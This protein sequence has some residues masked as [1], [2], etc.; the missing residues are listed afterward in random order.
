[1]ILISIFLSL[2]A[3]AKSFSILEKN[4]SEWQKS[5]QIEIQAQKKTTSA[6]LN[7]VA[8]ETVKI[9]IGAQKIRLE[10]GTTDP[11]LIIFDGKYLWNIQLPSKDFPDSLEVSRSLITKKNKQNL[12]L[13]DLLGKKFSS[14]FNVKKSETSEKGQVFFLEQKAK[15]AVVQ[16][17][18]VGFVE[19]KL[20]FISFEDDVKNKTEILVSNINLKSQVDEALFKYK[21]DPKTKVM[22][23]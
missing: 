20:K 8:D 2:S 4:L 19:Q 16:N 9:F 13:I 7:K 12:F 6:V 17:I 3:S 21:P 11:Q 1:M 10:S 23:L 15:P 22:D 5:K 14:A 18:Q